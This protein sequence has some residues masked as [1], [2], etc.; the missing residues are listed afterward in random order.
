VPTLDEVYRKFGEAS[1]AAQLLET[2]IGNILSIHGAIDAGLLD[3]PNAA[4]AADLFKFINRQTLGQ[5]L[6]SLHRTDESVSQLEGMLNRALEQRNRLSHSFYREH[7]FHRNS[8]E[9]R[10][11]MMRDLE[12]IHSTLLDAYK[13]VMLLSGIDL[14]KSNIADLPTKH[15]P[16]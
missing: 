10:S 9:G 1:E 14:E 4:H 7:N 8:D 16:I 12:L 6:R 11:F 15:V 5:L 3:K 13:A 2:E